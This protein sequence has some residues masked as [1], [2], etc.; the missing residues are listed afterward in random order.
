MKAGYFWIEDKGRRQLVIHPLNGLIRIDG[1]AESFTLRVNRLGHPGFAM[2]CTASPNSYSDLGEGIGQ[3]LVGT[4]LI[5][6]LGEARN[7]AGLERR[8]HS[9][10]PTTEPAL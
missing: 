4:C 9:M 1:T 3:T 5:E 10:P 2:R 8:I 7:T 6:D